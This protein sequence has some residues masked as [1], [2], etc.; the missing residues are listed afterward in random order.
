MSEKGEIK[1]IGAKAQKNSGRGHYQK[2]DALLD[3]FTVD[4]KE[5][6]ESFSLSKKV[7]Q[8]IC[9]DAV[10]NGHTEPLLVVA[11]GKE[12]PKTRLWVV[13]EDVGQDYIRLRKLE[14][15][16]LRNNTH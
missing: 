8:K 4:V 10:R 13:T 6:G 12:H 5:Y 16:W 1:R 14:E 9:L 7:W 11:L 15:E 2:G 3:I